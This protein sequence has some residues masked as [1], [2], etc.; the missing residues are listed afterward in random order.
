MD[1]A[2]KDGFAAALAV[3]PGNWSV[4]EW[5]VAWKDAVARFQA[6]FPDDRTDAARRNESLG[7]AGRS[8]E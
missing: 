7:S 8:I 1:I 3:S 6:R 5:N 4:L 2:A